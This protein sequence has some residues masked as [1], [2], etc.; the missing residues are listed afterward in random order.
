MQ[1]MYDLVG[2]RL[3]EIFDAQ[4]VDI[5]ILDRDD[6][7]RSS[8]PYIDRARRAVP[9]RADR[10]HRRSASTSLETREPVVVN[11]RSRSGPPRSGSRA[12]QGETPKSVRVRARSSSA[13]RRPA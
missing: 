8:F 1:A 6:R 4:V 3:R 13:G 5:G 9:G 10:A 12:C 7:P 11:E 2:D